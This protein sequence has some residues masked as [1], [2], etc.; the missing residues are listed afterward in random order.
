[1]VK[2][3]KIRIAVAVDQDGQWCACGWNIRRGSSK[4]KERIED[5]DPETLMDSA[6]EGV[7]SGE[8]RYW[9]EVEVESPEETK[10]KA[11]ATQ[12]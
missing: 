9:V 3:K 12:A 1:M 8:N 7:E 5:A 10:V 2:K 6:I 4:N 11:N